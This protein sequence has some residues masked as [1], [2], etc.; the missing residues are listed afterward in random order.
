[1]GVKQSLKNVAARIGTSA[2]YMRDT[3][4]PKYAQYGDWYK[5]M[6]EDPSKRGY[7][8]EIQNAMRGN[9]TGALAGARRSTM[10]NV[11][12]NI[13]ASGMGNTGMATH[14]ARKMGKDYATQQRE[15]NR[16]IDIAN[17]EAQR[18]DL[19]NATQA[20]LA[21]MG[22]ESDTQT[23]AAQIEGMQ[24]PALTGAHDVSFWG[25]WKDVTGG[26]NS[27]SEALNRGNPFSMFSK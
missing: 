17:A 25:D 19:W 21:G 11:N 1:M 20:W 10:E 24:V 6:V 22:G 2:D 16:D 5:G 26:L 15:A 9:A 23:R 18:A 13:A 8:A 14:M 3:M 27:L 7:S 12:K 4:T